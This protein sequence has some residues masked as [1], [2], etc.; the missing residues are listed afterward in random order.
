[1]A[2]S[3]LWAC[4]ESLD[5]DVEGPDERLTPNLPKGLRDSAEP[6]FSQLA[7]GLVLSSISHVQRY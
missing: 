6:S 1:M 3:K 4:P 2:L 5:G 7:D